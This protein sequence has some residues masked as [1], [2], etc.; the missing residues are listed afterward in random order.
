M[1][2]A[3]AGGAGG[4][5]AGAGLSMSAMAHGGPAASAIAAQAQPTHT[6]SGIPGGG[7]SGS[8]YG[9]APGT[10]YAALGADLLD[11]NQSFLN[12]KNVRSAAKLPIVAVDLYG[13]GCDVAYFPPMPKDDSDGNEDEMMVMMKAMDKV[14]KGTQAKSVAVGGFGS[15]SGGINVT[16]KK[17]DS[18]AYKAV[19]KR[20]LNKGEGRGQCWRMHWYY[21][22]TINP[23]TK[24][25]E[26]RMCCHPTSASSHGSTQNFRAQL[27]GQINLCIHFTK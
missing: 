19:V 18:D 12:G 26:R 24:N 1:S 9:A 6:H 14:K 11:K 17:D 23:Q 22:T 2:L 3:T 4:L 21:W 10:S 8:G 5:G 16:L 15:G 20:Y 27:C 7:A 13:D 25:Q